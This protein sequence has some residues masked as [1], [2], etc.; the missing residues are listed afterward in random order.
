MSAGH[1]SSRLP[2]S[3]PNPHSG[4]AIAELGDAG[5]DPPGL[6]AGG[7][8]GRRASSRFILAIDVG[9]RLPVGVADDENAL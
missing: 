3:A 7:Q 5:G 2:A 1:L 4:R 6:V 9:E 8:L